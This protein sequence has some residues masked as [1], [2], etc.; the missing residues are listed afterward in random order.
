LD[1][2]SDN[3]R[4]PRLSE[5]ESKVAVFPP[6]ELVA[7]NK[8]LGTFVELEVHAE[9]LQACDGVKIFKT[10]DSLKVFSLTFGLWKVSDLLN[11]L[12]NFCDMSTPLLDFVLL[13]IAITVTTNV[14]FGFTMAALIEVTN[15]WMES[16]KKGKYTEGLV[17][18]QPHGESKFERLLLNLSDINQTLA[19]RF[20]ELLFASLQIPKGYVQGPLIRTSYTV[21]GLANFGYIFEILKRLNDL[22]YDELA[23]KAYIMRS[24]FSVRMISHEKYV[25]S[26]SGDTSD[27][28]TKI[29]RHIQNRKI[30]SNTTRIHQ[31]ELK[32]QNHIVEVDHKIKALL[33][34]KQES[35]SNASSR[36]SEAVSTPSLLLFVQLQHD[37]LIFDSLLDCWRRRNDNAKS[38]LDM[39]NTWAILMVRKVP[40]IGRVQAEGI[41]KN[42]KTE[43]KTIKEPMYVRLSETENSCKH[44][45][46]ERKVL[47]N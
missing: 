25:K 45:I 46:F 39:E 33:K 43:W 14:S 20:V 44:W 7:F 12:L 10:Q 21:V 3:S 24:R 31:L 29:L 1:F 2:F 47:N 11:S 36:S 26:L 32:L 34:K 40:L 13:V 4:K 9:P 35:S 19:D 6:H 5:K 30:K 8:D 22:D 38:L 18:A 15:C 37:I 42:G 41:R 27:M 23:M 17:F 16:Q 28:S